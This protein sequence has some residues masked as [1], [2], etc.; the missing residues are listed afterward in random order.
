MKKDP[1]IRRGYR[2]ELQK[3]WNCFLSL[4]YIHNEFVNIWTHLLPAMVYATMIIKEARFVLY[5]WTKG[6]GQEITLVRFYI[7]TSFLLMSL[8]VCLST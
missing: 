5:D 3:A 2:E 6:T 7:V 1:Q 4:F 8:S